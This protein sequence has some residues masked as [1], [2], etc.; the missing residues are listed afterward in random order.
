MRGEIY[1]KQLI[2]NGIL[3]GN[4]YV[5]RVQVLSKGRVS[6]KIWSNNLSIEP[7]GKFFGEAAEL[8]EKEV[9]SL[10]SQSTEDQTK[11]FSNHKSA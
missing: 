7:G 2:V 6:G 1:A 8:P 4:C 9:V 5:E 11:T 10:K 3:D